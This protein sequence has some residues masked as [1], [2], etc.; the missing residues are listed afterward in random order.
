VQ[1]KVTSK[2]LESYHDK[3]N[4]IAADYD[5]Y[6]IKAGHYVSLSNLITAIEKNGGSSI[7]EGSSN[8][9][10]SSSAHKYMWLSMIRFILNATIFRAISKC[11]SIAGFI[12]I[13]RSLLIS[14]GADIV[15]NNKDLLFN[16]LPLPSRNKIQPKINGSG[17]I[18]D[19]FIEFVG[20][21]NICAKNRNLSTELSD[22]EVLLESQ[23]S[24]VSTG[25]ELKIFRGELDSDQP[26][27]VSIAGMSESK[28][29]F[30]MRYGYCMVGKIKSEPENRT[31][32]AF[33][34]HGKYSK[35]LLKDLIDVP[36]SICP[37]DA[38]FA[39]SVE[40][41]VSLVFLKFI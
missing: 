5:K 8:W 17:Y 25:T 10:I 40:T 3:I 36:E 12:D 21:R 34:P 7:V 4:E 2:D 32:F 29:T 26:L 19:T 9:V 41:A 13:L 11:Q 38:V 15:V 33:S 22:G 30:P 23:C 37:E 39:P 27:D 16:L 28:M 31:Y 14:R 24:L 35:V 18:T 20:I 1:I 6:L